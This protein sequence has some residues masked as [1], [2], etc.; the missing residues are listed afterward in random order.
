[1]ATIIHT[2][3]SHLA[4][5]TN[6][7]RESTST[8]RFKTVKRALTDLSLWSWNL[9]DCARFSF[10]SRS[11]ALVP[12]ANWNITPITRT[13]ATARELGL[14]R[15]D[16]GSADRVYRML[17]KESTKNPG[18]Y[19]ARAKLHVEKLTQTRKWILTEV[20]LVFGVQPRVRKLDSLKSRSPS[21]IIN[22][23]TML[24][25]GV[26]YDELQFAYNRP[27]TDERNYLRPRDPIRGRPATLISL[28]TPTISLLLWDVYSQ[29]KDVCDTFFNELGEC[30]FFFLVI[31][32]GNKLLHWTPNVYW[33]L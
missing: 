15:G 33:S 23:T 31:F 2:T 29:R 20:R 4:I 17:G 26:G 27:L 11:G 3:H 19:N 16:A 7:P 8:G 28:V 12:P 25:G 13:Y 18:S 22:R 1:M 24:R 30:V 5:P 32:S 21:R 9:Y 10:C 14:G 6:C